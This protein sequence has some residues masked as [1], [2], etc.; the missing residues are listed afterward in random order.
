MNNFKT[1]CRSRKSGEGGLAIIIIVVLLI[2]GGFWW[3]FSAKSTAEKESRAFLNEA[4]QRLAVQHNLEFLTS[5]M[6]PA[7]KV[8]FPPSHQR[9]LIETLTQLGV[10]AQPIKIDGKLLYDSYFFKPHGL[11]TAQ[12]NY[13]GRPGTLEMEISHPVGRWQF[14]AV[15]LGLERP[16]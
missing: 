1:N 6:G 2:G 5:R 12:L 11:F 3:L 15:R 9:N 16:R 13:P 7:A 4:V 10:P 14:D 8:E